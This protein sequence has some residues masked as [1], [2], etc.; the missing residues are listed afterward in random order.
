MIRQRGSHHTVLA[1]RC[2]CAAALLF[3]ALA[4]NGCRKRVDVQAPS[5]DLPGPVEDLTAIRGDD[6]VWLNWKM[7]ERA[8]DK[9]KLKAEITVCVCRRDNDSDVCA[10][11]REPFALAPGTA[12]SFSELLPAALSAGAPR[13]LYYFINPKNHNGYSAGLI[14]RVVTLAGAQPSPVEGLIAERERDGVLL[15][16]TAA[17]PE[18]ESASTV[19]KLYRSHV[20]SGNTDE[21]PPTPSASQPETVLEVSGASGQAFDEGAR[22]GESYEYRVQRVARVSVNGRVLELAGLLSAPERT[23]GSNSSASSQ[24]VSR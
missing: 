11:A 15:R 21:N 12:G 5:L 18:K 20:P 2:F 4:V 3:A 24:A 1:G 22:I 13:P 8:T 16:W 14:N 6:T 23:H 9:R 7:P 10:D 17:N 19:I